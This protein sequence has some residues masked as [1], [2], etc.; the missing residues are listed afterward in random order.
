MYYILFIHLLI[1]IY[2][3]FFFNFSITK[4]IYVVFVLLYS[5]LFE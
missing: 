2:L 4:Y 5:Q 1:E 3:V